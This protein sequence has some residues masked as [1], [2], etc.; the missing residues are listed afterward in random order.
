MYRNIL[1][2]IDPGHGDVGPRTV[3]L[4]KH[5]AGAE[6]RITLLTVLEPVPSFVETYIPRETLEQNHDVAERFLS[7]LAAAAA[8]QAEMRVTRGHPSKAILEVAEQIGADAIILGSHRPDFR[9]YLIGSTAARV[10][11]HA[12]CTVV[13]ERSETASA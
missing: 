4:A 10:V 2:P 8:L 13:V 12:G 5:L 6:G 7:D 9:D 1:V 3:A 11:R